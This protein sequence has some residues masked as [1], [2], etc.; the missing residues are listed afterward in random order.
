[1]F[2]QEGRVGNTSPVKVSRRG[3]V[4]LDVGGHQNQKILRS[5]TTIF[6][7]IFA[8]LTGLDALR[9]APNTS[10]ENN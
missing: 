2:E 1:M 10:Y 3:S 6:L 4:I 5:P 7:V 9:L 8:T